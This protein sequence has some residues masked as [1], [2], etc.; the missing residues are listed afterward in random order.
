MILNKLKNFLFNEGQV[1]CNEGDDGA[2]YKMLNLNKPFK[3]LITNDKV[4]NQTEFNSVV[5]D[6]EFVLKQDFQRLGF[7][8]EIIP[9]SYRNRLIGQIGSMTIIADND[10][11]VSIKFHKRDDD[12]LWDGVSKTFPEKNA[13]GKFKHE[14]FFIIEEEE[15]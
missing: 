1:E 7:D 11:N 3:F 8:F 13:T 15:E 2:Y 5:N 4:A 9:P 14:I 6:S 12:G 10:G